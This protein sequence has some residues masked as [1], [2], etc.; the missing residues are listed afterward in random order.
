MKALRK[1]S[2][3]QNAPVIHL[4]SLGCAK[5]QV[6]SEC[7]LGLLVRAGFLIADD[8]LQADIGLVNTCGF[9][10]DARQEAADT[11]AELRRLR[12]QGRPRFLVA[13]GCLVERAGDEPAL[14]GFLK[15]ADLRIPFSQYP[16]LPVICRRLLESAGGPQAA[17]ER[18]PNRPSPSGYMQFLNTPRLRMGRAHTA[19]LKLSEGC[20]NPCRFCS[21]PLIRGRQVSRPIEE[22]VHEAEQLLEGGAREINLIAQDTTAYG[23]DL[24]GHS[25]L[26]EL[27][28]AL[29]KIPGDFWIRLLYAY[30]GH[31]TGEVMELLAGH[32]RCCPYIDLP[33]QHI[34]DDILSAMGRKPGRKETLKLLDT[35]A[36]KMPKGALR[37]AFIVGFPG[38][39]RRHFNA[40]LDL[41]REG[42]F[43]HAGVF[44]YSAELGTPS[45]RRPAT[46]TPEEAGARRD[47]L[48]LAQQ[49]ISRSRL[50]RRVG[51]METI[52]LDGPSEDR[53]L[54]R[55]YPLV[56][57]TQL[58]APDV[59]GWV[60]VRPSRRGEVLHPGDRVQGQLMESSEY[61]LFAKSTGIFL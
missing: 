6:D 43:S 5:N 47:E 8:P 42:R 51:G 27:L 49:E 14:A 21:I 57:R 45:A 44:L 35:I 19:F 36:R 31:L 3:S 20:S 38:E 11:L 60:Y 41:V 30:P 52:L 48:L 53:K 55:R 7:L 2:K 24:Y 9:I 39:E 34:H 26:P 1:H 40:L 29:L 18:A 22:L 56:G 46:V 54:G 15:D 12:R 25:R 16:E 17:Q 50:A 10:H 37:T 59:D 61:D 33:L 23:R 4:V 58:E 13:T 32:P 28:K